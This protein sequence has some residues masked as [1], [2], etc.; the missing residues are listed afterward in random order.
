MKQEQCSHASLRRQPPN[1]QRF[2][3]IIIIDKTLDRFLP[4]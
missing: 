4:I 1:E 3:T 2:N